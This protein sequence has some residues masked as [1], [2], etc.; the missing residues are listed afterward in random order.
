MKIEHVK[1][2][3]AKEIENRKEEIV[4]LLSRLVSIPSVSGSEKACQEFIMDVYDS[5]GLEIT[6]WVPEPEKINRF[7]DFPLDKVKYEAPVVLGTLRGSG[8]GRSL[9]LSGHIDTVPPGEPETWDQDPWGGQVVDDKVYGR[10]ASDMKGG[11]AA[12][13][14]A[15]RSIQEMGVSLKGTVSLLSV[16]EEETGGIGV[17]SFVE[18]GY[19]YDGAI[20]PEPT[21]ME[22]CCAQEGSLW[23]RVVVSGKAAHA[24][25]RYYGISAIDKAY[26]IIEGLKALEEQRNLQLTNPLYKKYTNAFPINVGT[27]SGGNWP[28]SVPDKVQFEARLGISP[29]ED[30]SEARKQVESYIHKISELDAWLSHVPPKIEWYGNQCLASQVDTE[31]PLVETLR[32]AANT[33]SGTIFDLSGVP[34]GTDGEKLIRIARIPTVIF[35]PGT[36]PVMHAANEYVAVN[37]LLDC[38]NILAATI[39][40]WCG[41]E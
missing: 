1:Q 33:Y 9:L 6:S 37:N 36:M 4:Q 3:V 16:T 19:S 34:W 7:L 15:L 39:L 30:P 14:M 32:H 22:I 20:I 25:T 10:G 35:G 17:L 40:D 12:M 26:K 23:F 28:S 5:M 18:K 38:T 2:Q 11:I 31:H 21:N 24:G 27:I 41:V 8:K 29:S 13:I